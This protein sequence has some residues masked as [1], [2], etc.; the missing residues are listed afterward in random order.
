MHSFTS[1][2]ARLE[3]A[4]PGLA[5]AAAAEREEDHREIMRAVLSDPAAYDLA[6][7]AAD[8]IS[9]DADRSRGWNVQAEIAARPELAETL[10]ALGARLQATGCG[11][12]AAK[13]A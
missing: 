10:R 3:R 5:R 6:I 7:K 8:M 2:L 9:D 13:K 12:G 4:A 1:R 11:A